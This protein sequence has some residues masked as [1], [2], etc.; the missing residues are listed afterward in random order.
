MTSDLNNL[1]PTELAER[2]DKILSS[3][4]RIDREFDR[5]RKENRLLVKAEEVTWESAS[6]V[7][8][9]E[10]KGHQ[11]ARII[12]PELGFNIHTFRVF[13]RQIAGR[14]TDGA[15]HTHGDAVKYYLQGK[16]KEIIG[17]DE[18]EVTP[19][20]LAFI[21]A[22]VWHGTE[23]TGDE[24]MV[25]IAFHQIPGTHLPV[26]ASWQYPSS[27]ME[28]LADLDGLIAS[29][30]DGDLG[31]MNSAALYSKR[32]HFLHELGVLDDEMNLRRQAKRYLVRR[33]EVPW[34]LPADRQSVTLI[35]PELGFDIHTL[36]L[37]TRIVPP[38]Y[39]D[40][41]LHSHGEAVH[42]FLSGEGRQRVGQEDLPV[43]AGDLVFIPA[44]TPHGIS[45]SDGEVMRLL[46]AEQM[47]G[48]S[49]QRPVINQD[50]G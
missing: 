36:Q 13:K 6:Q 19:G 38:G 22:N 15:F 16:G 42:Y 32:Q 14:E 8:P 40:A 43:S 2:R 35:A 39:S 5:R 41:T 1:S 3:F 21:P 7:H 12:S 47:P 49:V 25:F 29:V 48:T 18:I 31:S 4:G 46:V 10:Q 45:N 27:D 34:E 28:G 44:G 11:L 20:D 33:D 9:T 30:P 50:P 23:N 26:P 17:D 24:P 37:S